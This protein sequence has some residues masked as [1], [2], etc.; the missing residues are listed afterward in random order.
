MR[1]WRLRTQHQTCNNKRIYISLN[2]YQ[3]SLQLLRRPTLFQVKTSGNMT[4]RE[5]VGENNKKEKR[6]DKEKKKKEFL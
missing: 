5:S 1:D 2:S 6:G 4:G 3:I